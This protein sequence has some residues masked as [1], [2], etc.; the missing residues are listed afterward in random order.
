MAF[1]APVALF[2]DFDS[3]KKNT[4]RHFKTIRSLSPRTKCPQKRQRR[5]DS[6]SISSFVSLRR[7][8]SKKVSA[9]TTTDIRATVNTIASL[10]RKLACPRLV[11]LCIRHLRHPCP[12]CVCSF[13]DLRIDAV[14]GGGGGASLPTAPQTLFFRR[15]SLSRAKT[16]AEAP[17][18]SSNSASISVSGFALWCVAVPWLGDDYFRYV[19]QYVALKTIQDINDDFFKKEVRVVRF[20]A[21]RHARSE[22]DVGSSDAVR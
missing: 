5:P 4:R 15:P 16:S 2:H 14:S 20:V 19:G 12:F 3:Q 1:L 22:F 17:K 13:R 18:A 7:R 6:R 9:T 11:K 21:E 10:I 8:T